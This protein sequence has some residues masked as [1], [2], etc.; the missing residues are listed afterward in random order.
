MSRP[1]LDVHSIS[2]ADSGMAIAFMELPTDVRVGGRVIQT[3]QVQ[4]HA[5]HPDYREAIDEILT[6]VRST[7]QSALDDFADSE[8][9]DPQV[10]DDEDDE[11]GM[12]E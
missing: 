9:F 12:G 8:P 1:T 7:L 2:F 6:L 3:R 11:R 4:L 10:D 5:S